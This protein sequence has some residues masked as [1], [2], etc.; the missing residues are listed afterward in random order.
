MSQTRIDSLLQFIRHIAS[1]VT[2]ASMYPLEHRQVQHLCAQALESFLDAVDEQ[3]EISL[4]R[5]DDQII[6]EGQPLGGGMYPARF[7][8]M[9]KHRS[10]GLLRIA[11]PVE[12]EEIVQL[13]GNLA[14]G[15]EKAALHSSKNIRYGKLELRYGERPG[16]SVDHLAGAAQGEADK[17]GD[18]AAALPD[19]QNLSDEQLSRLMEIFESSRKKKKL[20]TVGISEIVSSFIG[21]FVKE[22][23][24]L[25]ALA[26]LRDLDEYS[27]THSINVCIL[28]L[29]QAAAL[30]I[31]G[32]LLHDL[33][34]AALLH[35]IGKTTIPEEVLNKKEPLT[36]A[37]WEMIRKHP[38][39][40]A[41]LL[42]AAPG[43]PRLAV[44]TAYE[45]HLRFDG[46][47]YPTVSGSW[48]QN[49]S[50]YMTAI[51]D[52]FDAMSTHRVYREAQDME[53]VL[54]DLKYLGGTH[55]HPLLTEN[56]TRIIMRY[57]PDLL[58]E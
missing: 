42:L 30:G 25:L 13:V 46:S 6:F 3:H 14:K 54:T 7:A 11:Q 53:I 36:D 1:G 24:P 20:N 56:F 26:P 44:I 2:T 16:Q 8:S 45:H 22:A 39:E 35:D 9:L 57:R 28:N 34:T 21:A 52:V 17:D 31:E 33:G 10:I 40:G 43:V 47:G 49:I 23:D 50:S 51:S 48:E 15:R 37:E 5:I 27:F 55:L 19:Y 38:F 58:E 32:P 29:A 41:K 18:S 4:H 12:H